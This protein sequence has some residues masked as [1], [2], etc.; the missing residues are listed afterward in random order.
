MTIS[1][2]ELAMVDALN[3]DRTTRGLV[4]VRIDSRLMAIARAR[5]ADMVDEGLLQPLPAPVAGTSSAS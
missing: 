5:S 4:P 2:A 3:V 1:Q